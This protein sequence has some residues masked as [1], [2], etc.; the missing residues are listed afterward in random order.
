MAVIGFTKHINGLHKHLSTA[1]AFVR[2]VALAGLRTA[3]GLWAG[4][5]L[6]AVTIPTILMLAILPGEPRRRRLVRFSSRVTFRLIGAVPIVTGMDQL[7]ADGCVVVANHASYLDGIVMTAVL[8]P[9]FSFVIKREMTRV[10]FAH[11]LLRR[12]GSLFVERF[13]SQA[14]SRDA[15]RIMQHARQRQSLVFF[16]EGT[17]RDEPGLRKFHNGAFQA[18]RRSNAPLVPVTIRGSRDMMP[19]GR[20]L[21][22]PGRLE[23]IVHAPVD[24]SAGDSHELIHQCRRRILSQ[25]DE[26]DLAN[27]PQPE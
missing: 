11:F 23:V 27:Q 12:I 19:A 3:Y 5:A 17:F 25:L 7:P 4:L 10:P 6:V 22:W 9:R 21:P 13:D 1:A 14:R 16:P 15:R 26:P 20:L 2:S 8:P 24:S 18:A